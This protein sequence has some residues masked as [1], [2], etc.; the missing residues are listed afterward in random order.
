[1]GLER[2]PL[3]LVSTILG[4]LERKRSSL[5]LENR[6]YGSRD[7]S[8]WPRGTLYYPQKVG[9]NFSDKQLS[10]GRYSS[11]ADSGHGVFL[12]LIRWTST[13]I[14]RN[15]SRRQKR[16]RNVNWLSSDWTAIQPRLQYSSCIAYIWR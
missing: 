7:P 1:V 13:D 3:S 14:R 15:V 8:H 16:Q 4:L 2:G 5:R 10:L 12:A 9:I 6:D 11:L